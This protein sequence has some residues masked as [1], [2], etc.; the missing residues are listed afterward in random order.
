MKRFRRVTVISLVA[1]ALTACGSSLVV[2]DIKGVDEATAKTLLAGKGLIPAIEQKFS[3]T[4]ESG[5]VIKTVPAAGSSVEPDSRI[6][7]IISKGPSRIDASDSSIEWYSLGY[8]DDDWNFSSP[9]IEDGVLKIECQP[10]F[11]VSMSW[12]DPQSNG[13]GFGRAS[14]SDTFDKTVP[15]SI[16]FSKQ[17]WPADARQNITLSVP[18]SDLDVQQ[19][20]TLYLELYTKVNGDDTDLKINFSI[21]W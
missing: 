15:V 12:R 16:E 2:P 4:V 10:K 11:A 17:T 3:D 1:L 19:P 14:I 6:R 9:Y 20:T 7:V 13:A 21:S 8:Q 18:V 5:Q